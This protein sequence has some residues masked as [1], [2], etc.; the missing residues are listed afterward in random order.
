MNKNYIEFLKES[1][2]FQLSLTS[3][4]LF[5]SNFISWVIS[6][7]KKEHSRIFS[8]FLPG[9]KKQLITGV[10]REEKN[11]DIVIYFQDE[12]GNK[13]SIIIE[14]KVKSIPVYEQLREYTTDNP[15]EHY[16]LLS[17]TKPTFLADNKKIQIHETNRVWDYLSYYDLAKMFEETLPEIGRNN[18][19]HELIVSDYIQ[20]I[21][22]LDNITNDIYEQTKGGMYDFYKKHNEIIS[23]L[24]EVRLHDFYLKL[25]HEIIASEL[26]KK[27]QTEIP[28]VNLVASKNWKKGK[29]NELFAGSGF[30]R[31]S[32]ISEV[33]Y[34]IAEKEE[35]PV[36]LG[37]QIQ[38]VQFRLFIE[39]KKGFAKKFA[40]KLF[41]EGI[42]FNFSYL[43]NS[44]I[45]TSKEYPQTGGSNKIF[46]TYSNEFLYRSVK[47][48]RCKI[49][50]LLTIIL[51]YVH[52]IHNDKEKF[53]KIIDE[54]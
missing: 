53:L 39:S 9:D 25:S 33:K 24:K 43:S 49:S 10:N 28:N 13:S 44:G 52:V 36:I 7:Y 42:W 1:P 6:N 20:L 38:D 47:L 46:N 11:K 8:K 18:K 3:K 17:L 54:L 41:D 15:S 26:H 30:T 21:K 22:I 45:K 4:E 35:T 51:Y 32:G 19:Y 37:V 40:Q 31:G 48:D 2:M 16:I 29:V 12:L 27:I 23:L 5:H 34:V 50:D 14:N